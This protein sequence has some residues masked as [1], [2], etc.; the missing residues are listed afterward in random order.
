M[1]AIKKMKLVTLETN[2]SNGDKVSFQTVDLW[3]PTQQHR[4]ARRHDEKS[5]TDDRQ[6]HVSIERSQQPVD[7]V[8][9]AG[10]TKYQVITKTKT[11]MKLITL[12]DIVYP[13][14]EDVDL[15]GRWRKAG[16]SLSFYYKKL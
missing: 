12:S 2:A 4:K 11:N 3:T 16:V 9:A 8:Y 7:V 10:A 1:K 13:A 15:L 6:P 5:H 14:R